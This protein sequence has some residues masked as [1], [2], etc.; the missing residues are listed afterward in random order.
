MDLQRQQRARTHQPAVRPSFAIDRPDVV[1]R[2]VQQAIRPESAAL[3]G[4]AL[5]ALAGLIV[6]A[7]QG[8]AQLVARS[9]PDVTTIR[10][11][12]ATRFQATLTAAGTGL[13]PVL[14]GTVLA[15]AGALALSPLAPVGPV[16]GST[17][18][19]DSGPTGRSWGRGPCCWPFC[20]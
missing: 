16:A 4:V 10:A 18:S 13:A 8:L 3:G 6:L 5:A 20:C 14:G 7:G 15:V 9:A 17:R 2:Q 1:H 19:A 12:G 11:L